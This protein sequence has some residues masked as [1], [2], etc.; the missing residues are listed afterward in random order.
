[1]EICVSFDYFP[2]GEYQSKNIAKSNSTS[3]LGLIWCHRNISGI[4]YHF[5]R[6]D[7]VHFTD[8]RHKALILCICKNYCKLSTATCSKAL[9]R[10]VIF[11]SFHWLTSCLKVM[12][13]CYVETK[14]RCHTLECNWISLSKLATEIRKPSLAEESKRIQL[15]VMHVHFLSTKPYEIP[16]RSSLLARS[17]T[18]KV[19]AP[20][21][22]ST[23]LIKGQARPA[24]SVKTA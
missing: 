4:W 21:P 23:A 15:N 8:R 19:L 16:F 1:M 24:A 9:E 13:V 7:C 6:E 14:I 20:F 11:L 3:Q 2:P 5:P 12:Q 18:G 22:L 10:Q 17:A